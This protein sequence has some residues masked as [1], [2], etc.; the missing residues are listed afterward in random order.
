MCKCR[1]KLKSVN[2]IMKCNKI[3]IRFRRSENDFRLFFGIY[4]I[5]V[6]GFVCFIAFWNHSIRNEIS[7]KE[8][9]KPLKVSVIRCDAWQNYNWIYEPIWLHS[10]ISGIIFD[11]VSMLNFSNRCC[12]CGVTTWQ[13]CNESIPSTFSIYLVDVFSNTHTKKSVLVFGIYLSFCAR[14]SC[15]TPTINVCALC[16]VMCG[17]IRVKYVQVS[18]FDCH[19]ARSYLFNSNC[20]RFNK[21]EGNASQGQYFRRKSLKHIE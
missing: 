8:I 14:F 7:N 21:T 12:H 16:H 13:R 4:F 2:E 19:F 3:N 6:S 10:N 9:F 17:N 20:L 18:A 1:R 11:L 5:F 15:V